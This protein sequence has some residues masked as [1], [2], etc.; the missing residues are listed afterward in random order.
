MNSFLKTSNKPLIIKRYF[1]SGN[2]FNKTRFPKARRS[3]IVCYPS[4]LNPKN[5]RIPQ[6]P[7]SKG[8]SH[9]IELPP[10]T[11]IIELSAPRP[12]KAQIVSIC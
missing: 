5:C 11:T 8:G 3:C 10:P 12:T 9:I 4:A 2:E 1:K 7:F 6:C